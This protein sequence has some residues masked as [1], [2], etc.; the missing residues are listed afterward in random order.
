M[1]RNLINSNSNIVLQKLLTSKAANNVN[2][3]FSHIDIQNS[4]VG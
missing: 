3:F 2:D 4:N 1:Q